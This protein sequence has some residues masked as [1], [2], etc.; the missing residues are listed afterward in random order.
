[1]KPLW[2]VTLAA[3]FL[4][5]PAF[6]DEPLAAGSP[7]ATP[8]AAELSVTASPIWGDEGLVPGQWSEV[9]VVLRNSGHDVRRGTIRVGGAPDGSG[10]GANIDRTSFEVAPGATVEVRMPVRVGPDA[11]LSV[12]VRGSDGT[13]LHE[14]SL[15]SRRGAVA[16]ATL[17]E[18]GG[19]TALKSHLDDVFAGT[20][21]DPKLAS[22]GYAASSYGA[23]P[24]GYGGAHSP[25][26]VSVLAPS[27]D[28][29]TA[30]AILPLRAASYSAASA[31]LLRSDALVRLRAPELAALTGWVLSG[32]TL[33]LVVARPEDLRNPI[34]VAL[35]GGEAS[36]AE[37]APETLA[38]VALPTLPGSSGVTPAPLD[39]PVTDELASHLAGYRGGN[40]RASVFGATA[41]YGLGEVHLLALDPEAKP[42]I[43]ARFTHVRMVELLRR[44]SERQ[45]GI[46]ARAGQESAPSVSVRRYLDPNEAARG[47]IGLSV[48]LLCVYAV[49]A[50][51]V[52]FAYWRRRGSPLKSLPTLLGASVVAFVMIA[53]IALASKGVRGRARHLTLVEAGAGMPTGAARRFRAMFVPTARALTVQATSADAVLGSHGGESVSDVNDELALER[54]ALR[55]VGLRLRPWQTHLVRE[56]GFVSLGQGIALAREPS[57]GVV[58]VNRTGR[59]LR[60]LILR[61]PGKPTGFLERLAGGERARP[62]EFEPLPVTRS[63]GMGTLGIEE[64]A[65]D[66]AESALDDRLSGLGAAWSALHDDVGAPFDW[67]PEDVPVLLAQVEGG[68]GTTEDSGLRLEHDRLLVRIVGYGGTP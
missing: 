60:G 33:A 3:A 56:D 22:P 46:L 31:V 66:S 39:E 40:L 29:A 6:A 17:V 34:V 32:G 1:V 47:P 2:L 68:E 4:V 44:A 26:T 35:L 62:A 67:F 20:F 38:V 10:A 9:L 14:A 55:I 59:T 41:T 45:L 18:V 23:P 7:S 48:L 65:I 64:F 24:G 16:S 51:P 5:T 27:R 12:Q 63:T 61:E 42:A 37:V 49:L 36:V 15:A 54:D 11:Q 30:E 19:F 58:V 43:D 52:N 25:V 53:G 13:A 28:A 21:Y 8:S 57:G 50:G